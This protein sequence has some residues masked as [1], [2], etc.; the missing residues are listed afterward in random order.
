[1]LV[2][3]QGNIIET[4]HIYN[5][6]PIAKDSF[7]SFMRCFTIQ[8]INKKDLN[9]YSDFNKVANEIIPETKGKIIHVNKS[10]P[11]GIVGESAYYNLNELQVEQLNK[12]LDEKANEMREKLIEY[13]NQSKSTIPEIK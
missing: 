3:I 4:L 9:I 13:W 7:Y 2:N 11:K 6:T 1:M 10:Y 8:F 12:A 5:I